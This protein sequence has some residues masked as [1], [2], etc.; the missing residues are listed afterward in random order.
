MADDKIKYSDFIQPDESI[1][2]VIKQLNALN[3]T[4]G[5]TLDTI[6]QNAQAL[7]VALSNMSGATK[8]GR[9]DIETNY[10]TT[11]RLIQA[12]NELAL[13][14]SGVGQQIT[15]LKARTAE[16]N[17]ATVEQVRYAQQAATSYARIN[18]D[19]KDSVN[20]YKS[21]TAE[22]RK[23]ADM[24]GQLL[25]D[26]RQYKAQLKQLD[27]E[28]KLHI[29]TTTEVEKA[30]QRLAF[31]Q[32]AEGQKLLDLKAKISAVTN[33]RK[34]KKE[35]VSALVAAQQKLQFAM[36]NENTALHTLNF[37][38]NQAN[39]EAELNAIIAK[40][41]A[42][43]Y[44]YLAAQYELCK[45]KLNKLTK[46]ERENTAAG[47]DLVEE[48]KG[49]YYQMRELQEATGNFSLGVGDYKQAWRGLGFSISQVVRELPAAAIG[50]NTFF[51]AISNNVPMVID[52]IQKLRVQNIALAKEGKPT[53]SI[54]KAIARSLFSWNTAL[55]LVLT[56]LTMF[57]EKIIAWVSSLIKGKNAVITTTEAVRNLNK[58]LE[59]SG[60]SY[61]ETLVK[62]RKLQSEWAKLKTLKDQNTWI[63][64][65]TT[66]FNN[67]GLAIN[68]VNDA[69]RAFVTDTESVLN[70][71]KARAKAEA[72]YTLASKEYEK[73]FIK[74]QQ[75]EQAKLEKPGVVDL[76]LGSLATGGMAAGGSALGS[77][78][79]ARDVTKNA[80]EQRQVR[81]RGLEAEATAAETNA[82][83][84][85]KLA[86][87]EGTY[88]D[89]IL[90]NL[91]LWGKSGKEGSKGRTPR[92][93]EDTLESLSLAATK[94][95]QKS[96]TEL[97]REEIA[98]RRQQAKAAEITEIKDLTRK[99]NKIRRILAGED[100]RYKELTEDQKQRALKAQDEL[101]KAMQN[102]RISTAATLDLLDYA[103]QEHNA[104]ALLGTLEL[105]MKAVK[106]GSEEELALRLKILETEE[107]I[108]L[109]R[110]AQL[111]PSEQQKPENIK[112]G[113]TKQQV[114]LVVESGLST[115]EQYQA[116]EEAEFNAVRHNETEITKFKLKQ[117]KERWE[118]QLAYAEAGA[119]DWSQAQIDAAKATVEGLKREMK[120]ADDFVGLIGEQGVEGALLTKLG[121]DDKQIAAITQAT[122]IIIE[123]LSAIAQAEI[124]A[125]QAAVDA[126]KER[127][128]AA[129]AAYDAEIEAR[130]NGY[131]NNVATAAR[132]LE[133]ERKKEREKQKI[134]EQAQ[135]RKEAIDTITQT[136]SLIT[137][138][139]LLWQSF[140]GTGPAAPFLA[141]AAIAAMWTSFAVAKVKAR[142]AAAASE[143]YGEGGLE[144]LEGGSHASGNDIDLG[145]TNKKG[146]R[147]RAEGGEALAIINKRR[148]R[149]YKAILPDIVNSLNKG[150]FEDK[151]LN[152]F[153][154]SDLPSLNVNNYSNSAVD[155]T[156]IES[157]VNDIKKQNET[158]YF[159]LSDGTTVMMY[160]NV[161]RII[162]K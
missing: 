48:T 124:D 102:K 161:K 113:F 144:F 63:K 6:K 3:T 5:Y 50:M 104:E 80:E 54:S 97:E 82:E 9:L 52:E 108:A 116:L 123:N 94:A 100:E 158:R 71:F 1:N 56:A 139:A 47:R 141:A 24:G 153:S 13:A 8:K 39:K 14:M 96:L 145:T 106:E 133:Q 157:D 89:A 67:M 75:A 156:K 18:A 19:L 32:S 70:A 159:T 43:S 77:P 65:N 87:A 25:Q 121:F 130:N 132:E 112:A 83:A 10:A 149:Q 81:I 129:Q 36:S 59:E 38:T 114:G 66:E 64:N 95:Y 51:L 20:L 160:K 122:D 101:I 29:K 126:A 88:A 103:E 111:P 12:E 99:Y 33:A 154:T 155:I 11:M 119:L 127:V 76:F 151:Y 22:E 69:N 109:A 28:M 2:N 107:K 16:A 35:Q 98:K 86:D 30:E 49:I 23:Q 17:K 53:V 140:A 148:T 68:D 46:E 57:G 79:E 117:E 7:S 162:K 110:N 85:F 72:A 31:L 37:L 45:I 142:Q 42:G 34:Q 135:R 44:N 61:G 143:E 146:R 125:A 78:A 15:W 27:A 84:Y 92:D 138:S 40:S 60:S 134:L 73:A 131:A 62:Y 4:F 26:I 136:S 21:L 137:A 93:A 90:K 55:V 118:L 147:M 128:D 152:A 120:E 91:G 74:R 41:Q 105:Q 150:V 115:F 58:E